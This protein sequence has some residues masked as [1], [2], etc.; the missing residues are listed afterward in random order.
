MLLQSDGILGPL[1]RRGSRP[2]FGREGVWPK[3]RGQAI[4]AALVLVCCLAASGVGA[5][6]V[7]TFKDKRTEVIE[8]HRVEGAWT[9]LV[10]KGGEVGVPTEQIL[11]FRP[12]TE[13][14]IASNKP[15]ETRVSKPGASD[16]K[17][18]EPAPSDE[19]QTKPPAQT[20]NDLK[21][22]PTGP[23]RDGEKLPGMPGK[24]GPMGKRP[25]PGAKKTG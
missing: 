25:A 12:A 18:E 5:Y 20:L 14:E 9:Y 21:V 16:S 6:E 8:S 19:K 10:V 7:V 24:V 2:L 22:K 4:V 23:A 15:T 17:P 11:A 3:S 13:E 1:V